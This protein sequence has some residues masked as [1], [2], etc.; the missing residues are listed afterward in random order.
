MY[1]GIPN[2]L[3]ISRK[4]DVELVLFFIGISTDFRVAEHKINNARSINITFTDTARA[5]FKM[6]CFFS[7]GSHI[8][9]L[10]VQGCMRFSNVLV[11]TNKLLKQNG[12]TI[13]IIT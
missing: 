6:F 11:A 12:M 8:L 5:L 9:Q 3:T 13:A 7:I 2:I 10:V 4:R 1:E